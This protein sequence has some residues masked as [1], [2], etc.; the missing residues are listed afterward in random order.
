MH[1]KIVDD[2]VITSH[3]LFE[4]TTV[5]YISCDTLTFFAPDQ[6]ESWLLIYEHL[7]EEMRQECQPIINSLIET[8]ESFSAGKERDRAMGIVAKVKALD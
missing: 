4:K 2:R 1:I 8:V 7:S 3:D 6:L 5:N